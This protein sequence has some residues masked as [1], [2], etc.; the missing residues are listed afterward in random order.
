MLRRDDRRP[1]TRERVPTI[2]SQRLD[3]VSLAPAEVDALLAGTRSRRGFAVPE[4]WPGEAE[5]G[6]LRLRVAQMRD[7]ATTQQW[8]VR[9]MVLREPARRMIGHVGFH[10]PPGVNG[11]RDPEA[12]EIGFTVFPDFRGR[13]YA[14][15]AAR[16]LMGWAARERGVGSFIASVRPDNAPSLRVVAKLGF[17]RTGRQWDDIDGEELVFE[18]ALAG[19][20]RVARFHERAGSE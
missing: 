6:F 7:D 11:K 20:G 4:G 8:L 9:A 1:V 2:S 16:A 5:G 15:E 12:L 13:G 10:G 3:L 17:V 18:L 19:G 14:T